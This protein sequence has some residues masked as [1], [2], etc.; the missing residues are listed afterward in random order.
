MK[1]GEVDF[2]TVG[3]LFPYVIYAA[4]VLNAY[5]QELSE[6]VH[7]CFK[8][9]EGVSMSRYYLPG[10]WLPHVTIGKTLDKQQMRLAFEALQES[11]APF[12]GRVTAMGLASVN[13]HTDVS[14]IEL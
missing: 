2:V 9:L 5:L 12:T 4:P 14:V 11:F 10:S 1:G 13:P 3:Q 6:K 7:S 8:D